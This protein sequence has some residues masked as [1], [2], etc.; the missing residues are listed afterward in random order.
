M[1]LFCLYLYILAEGLINDLV[2]FTIIQLQF[3]YS[4]ILQK[5]E[6]SRTKTKQR[7]KKVECNP[8]LGALNWVINRKKYIEASK[9]QIKRYKNTAQT[10]KQKK[11]NEKLNN[12]M[13]N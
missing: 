13:F 5:S 9:S 1:L 7:I 8:L 4:E 12:E 10:D 3:Y 6:K 2:Y 11:L